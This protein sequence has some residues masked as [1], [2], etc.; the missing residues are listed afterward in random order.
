MTPDDERPGVH[1]PEPF[2]SHPSGLDTDDSTR[3][4]V[5]CNSA[6][7]EALRLTSRLCPE[8]HFSWHEE[9]IR[10][11][12][13]RKRRER[14]RTVGFGDAYAVADGWPSDFFYLKCDRCPR[15]WVGRDGEVCGSCLKWRGESA[16]DRVTR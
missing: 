3:L 1:V 4:C 15:V 16:A 11:D 8:C 14:E 12:D 7:A 9:L 6:P 10:K 5:S 2:L 13:E